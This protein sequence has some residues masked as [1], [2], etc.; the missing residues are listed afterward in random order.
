V[1]FIRLLVGCK[2]VLTDSGGIQEEATFLRKPC[3]TLR[4]SF[5]RPETLEIGTNTLCGLNKSLIIA[6]ANE[7]FTGRYKKGRIPK[8]MDG[9]ASRRIVN[10]VKSFF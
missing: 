6:K 9:K 4:E 1:D 7:I 5:E 3:L 2:F 8:L 10:A